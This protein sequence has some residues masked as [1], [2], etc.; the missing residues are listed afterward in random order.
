MKQDPLAVMCSLEGQMSSC[1]LNKV[2][3]DLA[4][5]E[6]DIGVGVD[7]AA[8]RLVNGSVEKSS[9]D[10]RDSP[11][12]KPLLSKLRRRNRGNGTPSATSGRKLF[13]G[14]L[15]HQTNATHLRVRRPLLCL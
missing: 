12:S 14:G 15:S 2:A 3:G 9:N 4:E 6:G 13:V 1:S 11:P 8:R 7:E 5:K 10:R